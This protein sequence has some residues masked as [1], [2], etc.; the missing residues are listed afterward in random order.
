VSSASNY[1]VI[2]GKN[3]R[4]KRKRARLTLE[5]LAERADLHPN[6]LGRVERAE[7]QISLQALIRVAKALGVRAQALLAGL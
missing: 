4:A 6:Y 1:R 3:I 7:E 2:L 5:A